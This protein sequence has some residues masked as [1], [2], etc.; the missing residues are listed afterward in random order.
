MVS[1]IPKRTTRPPK[2]TPRLIESLAHRLQSLLKL[3][4]LR[5]ELVLGVLQQ[6]LEVLDALVTGDELALGDG[7]VLL[8]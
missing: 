2:L 6:R 3:G 1:A 5:V 8:E 4:V 7:H